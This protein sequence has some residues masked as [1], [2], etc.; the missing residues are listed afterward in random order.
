[1]VKRA[2]NLFHFFCLP[3]NQ[4]TPAPEPFRYRVIPSPLPALRWWRVVVDEAHMVESTT[5]ETA[6]MALKI[7]AAHR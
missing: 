6:K 1:M 2:H 4:P 5:Q 7:P 3:R